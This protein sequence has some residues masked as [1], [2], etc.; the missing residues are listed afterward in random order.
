MNVVGDLSP[1]QPSLFLSMAAT[2][3]KVFPNSY[4]FAVDSPTET[5]VQNIIFVGYNSTIKL[6]LSS[7]QFANSPD[8]FIRSLHTQQIQMGAYDLSQYPILTDDY[9]PVEFL[10]APL[11][12]DL[13]VNE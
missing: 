6:D 11:I 9:A 12:K 2:F 5:G 1:Q 3:T 13:N 7:N 8:P 10:T 4:F